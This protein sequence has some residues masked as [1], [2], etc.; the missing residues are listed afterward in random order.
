MNAAISLRNVLSDDLPIFFDQQK[1]VESNIM[2]AF[3]S[4]DPNDKNAFDKHWVKIR[5]NKEIISR[6][7][8]V[9]AQI[10]V[11]IVS[12][13]MGEK[14]EV[15]YWIGKDYWGKG[16]VTSVL[17]KFISEI[18]IRPLSAHVAFDNYGSIKVLEKTGFIKIGEDF[19]FAK[20]RGK[21]IKE[22]IYELK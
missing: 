7:I 21:E 5:N 1:D 19:Y 8:L 20:A 12:F 10:S 13:I 14:R 15:G 16:I 17:T 4:R 18:K 11:Y 3:I 2:A 6:T 9:D 22:F